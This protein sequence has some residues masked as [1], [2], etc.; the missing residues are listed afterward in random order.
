MGLTFSSDYTEPKVV[1]ST[2][3]VADFLPNKYQGLWYEQAH[4]QGMMGLGE[5]QVEEDCIWASVE[6]KWL[7]DKKE[8][9]IKN[10]CYNHMGNSFSNTGV[11]RLTKNS[12]KL[13]IKFGS[14]LLY[15]YWV[16]WTDYNNFAIVGVPNGRYLWILSRKKNISP[17]AIAKMKL[18][19]EKYGYDTRY[20]QWNYFLY[21]TNIELDTKKNNNYLRVLHTQ[22]DMQ[23]TVMSLNPGE[24]IPLEKHNVSQFIRIETGMARIE[25]NGQTIELK[26]DEITIIKP[27][28][29]HVVKNVGK[30]VL[31]LYSVYSGV[32]HPYDEILTEPE[33]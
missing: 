32:T 23:L 10:T 2:E 22:R 27:D 3:T 15:P 14:G 12:G 5:S 4:P 8:M 31:K 24:I 30:G 1:P 9:T 29:Y 13:V 19:A 20:L 26:K 21:K 33:K 11:A 18:L 28:I 25:A 6:Y 7:P 17:P 16:H